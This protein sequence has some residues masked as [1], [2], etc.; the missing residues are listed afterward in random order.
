MA[1]VE[2]VAIPK[3]AGR[4]VQLEQ[5]GFLTAGGL[6]EAVGMGANLCIVATDTANHV[7]DA[8]RAIEL[9]LDV[10]V[11]KPLAA[12]GAEAKFLREQ[13][14]RAGRKLFVGCVL[15]FSK[16]LNKFHELCPQVGRLH[17]VQIQCQS[18]LPDWRP[19]RHY[20][21]SYSA[22]PGE[23]GVLLD[24]IHEV[25]YAGWLFGW[26]A[27]LQGRVRNLGRLGIAAEEAADLTWEAPTGCSVF[28]NLDYLSRPP[29]RR[30]RA[31]GE[32]GTIEWNGVEGTVVLMLDGAPVKEVRSSQTNADMLLA[33][34]QA[35]VC[36]G[37][38]APGSRLASS[39]DGVRALAIC[40]AARHASD[41][42]REEPVV[43]P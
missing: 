4:A 18:Y 41:N 31:Y 38:G 17:S 16:A 26:P 25:D 43:Y 21:D 33:Q 11:E 42:R 5:E 29:H 34:D 35:F 27:S 40:D 14:D 37:R 8:A 1:G 22:Q 24:L 30:M 20:R 12:S 32:L 10:L 6:E 9:G 23:G 15:R 39:E 13:A 19:N 36:A 3:R 7:P 28:L 2:A